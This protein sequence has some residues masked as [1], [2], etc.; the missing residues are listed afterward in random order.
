MDP[1]STYRL[2]GSSS[3]YF[4]MEKVC[5]FFTKIHEA[6]LRKLLIFINANFIIHIRQGM[7]AVYNSASHLAGVH[8]FV[9]IVTS[10]KANFR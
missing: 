3:Y 6:I 7:L 4:G 10:N 1:R 2:F 8:I 9:R 5:F